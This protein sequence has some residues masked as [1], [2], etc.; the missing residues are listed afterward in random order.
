MRPHIRFPVNEESQITVC[1]FCNVTLCPK[2]K[3]KHCWWCS[4]QMNILFQWNDSPSSYF[5]PETIEIKIICIEI[6]KGLWS[7]TWTMRLQHRW[8]GRDDGGLAWGMDGF[9]LELWAHPQPPMGSSVRYNL[10]LKEIRNHDLNVLWPFRAFIIPPP[11]EHILQ[12]AYFNQGRAGQGS[13]S[14]RWW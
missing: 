9:E 14:Q 11:P 10:Y 12:E 2:G 8:T 3:H 7:I 4:L 13:H 1:V 6:Q 5:L